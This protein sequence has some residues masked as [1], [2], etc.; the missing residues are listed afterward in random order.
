VLSDGEK[1]R[2]AIARAIVARPS[3]L[4]ADEPTG[5]LDPD[6]GLRLTQLFAE[7]NK[8]GTTV[9]MA[10][11]NETLAVRFPFASLRISEGQVS[12]DAR[13]AGPLS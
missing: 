9:V 4:L 8:I 1:Q 10:T 3:L 6:L 12:L 5:N 13:R 2:V 11:H 7:L